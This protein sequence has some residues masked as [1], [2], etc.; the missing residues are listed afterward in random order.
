MENVKVLLPVVAIVAICALAV[1]LTGGLNGM[2]GRDVARSAP[3]SAYGM[4]WRETVKPAFSVPIVSVPSQNNLI[5]LPDYISKAKPVCPNGCMFGGKG[6]SVQ[7]YN[8]VIVTPFS[9]FVWPQCKEPKIGCY[10]DGEIVTVKFKKHPY[11]SLDVVWY[12]SGLQCVG[13]VW[14]PQEGFMVGCPPQA[15]GP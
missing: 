14:V 9:N 4:T 11:Y 8:G 15:V 13:H 5:T 3:L 1:S 12:M 7:M 2:A 6:I 10:N